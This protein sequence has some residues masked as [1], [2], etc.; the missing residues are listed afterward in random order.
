M[1]AQ[2]IID[3]KIQLELKMDM[4]RKFMQRLDVK[5]KG[6]RGLLGQSATICARFKHL[7]I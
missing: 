4:E 2:T 6:F 5:T 7:I 3:K 1:K